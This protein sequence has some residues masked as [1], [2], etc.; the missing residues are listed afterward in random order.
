MKKTF[1]HGI[2]LMIVAIVA[3]WMNAFNQNRWL[4]ISIFSFIFFLL[5]NWCGFVL[6]LIW[7]CVQSKNSQQQQKGRQIKGKKLK[8]MKRQKSQTLLLWVRVCVCVS[9]IL[10][11]GT[12]Y[13]ALYAIVHCVAIDVHVFSCHVHVAVQNGLSWYGISGLHP[14]CTFALLLYFI[15]YF[16]F[17]TCVRVYWLFDLVKFIFLISVFVLCFVVLSLHSLL[18]L[19]TYKWNHAPHSHSH[20]TTDTSWEVMLAGCHKAWNMNFVMNAIKKWNLFYKY[21]RARLNCFSFFIF[22]CDRSCARIRFSIIVG[23]RAGSC[24]RHFFFSLPDFLSSR[25]FAHFARFGGC[26]QWSLFAQML[27]F[28]YVACI[29]WCLTPVSVCHN[30]TPT[31]SSLFEFYW[32]WLRFFP[33]C[34]CA[35]SSHR[36]FIQQCL[37]H[38]NQFK[39]FW[40]PH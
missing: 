6:I 24:I 27:L 26:C 17:V 30:S 20:S 12:L 4:T 36:L 25:L 14:V 39:W 33:S 38:K 32:V 23:I 11:M 7:L 21:V 16:C 8:A 22:V 19:Y 9:F 1:S 31:F 10:I 29:F 18:S 15:L 2:V 3:N 5:L 34:V 35:F 28:D 37:T 13:F 40:D